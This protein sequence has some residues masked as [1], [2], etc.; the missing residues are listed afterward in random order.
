MHIDLALPLPL[1]AQKRY[2][3]LMSFFCVIAADQRG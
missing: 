3:F 2:I 1:L